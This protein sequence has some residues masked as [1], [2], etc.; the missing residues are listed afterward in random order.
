MWDSIEA[1]GLEVDASWVFSVCERK[2]FGN[3]EKGVTS[4]LHVSWTVSLR[5]DIWANLW[6]IGR[7]LK[8][9]PALPPPAPQKGGDKME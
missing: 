3:A 8:N 6:K 5:S 7:R 9:I 2:C 4:Q 1:Y